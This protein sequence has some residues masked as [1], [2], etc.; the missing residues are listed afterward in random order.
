MEISEFIEKATTQHSF[1]EVEILQIRTNKILRTELVTYFN[2]NRHRQFALTLIDNF[3]ELRKNP[4]NEISI[5]DLML[6]SF[7]LGRHGQV[8]DCLKIWEAKTVDFDTYCGVDIQLVPFAGVEKTISFLKT[9][10]HKEAKEALEYV[11][12]CLKAGDF[13]D[14]EVYFNETP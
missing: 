13:D 2:T 5:D 7:I 6:A 9:E 8:E 12:G 14:L 11:L 3:I 4:E 1:S 10:T